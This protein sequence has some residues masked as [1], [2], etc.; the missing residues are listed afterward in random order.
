MPENGQIVREH[1]KT[2]LLG[3][4]VM[5]SSTKSTG[6]IAFK[7]IFD[8]LAEITRRSAAML[9]C[10]KESRRVISA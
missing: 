5:L 1:A 2:D 6:E 8:T 4:A 7:Y 10:Y 3:L 9:A